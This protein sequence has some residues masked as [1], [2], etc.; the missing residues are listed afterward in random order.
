MRNGGFCNAEDAWLRVVA[1]RALILTAMAYS[2][3]SCD[4]K[5]SQ[6]PQLLR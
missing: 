2:S 1:G 4:P 6:N 5:T 3:S